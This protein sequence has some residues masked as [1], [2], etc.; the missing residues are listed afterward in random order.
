M[1]SPVILKNKYRITFICLLLLSILMLSGCGRNGYRTFTTKNSFCQFSFEYP[2]AYSDDNRNWLTRLISPPLNIKEKYFSITFAYP[3]KGYR[4]VNPDP[5]NKQSNPVT[6]YHEPASIHI[7]VSESDNYTAKTLVGK[8]LNAEARW[9]NYNLLERS[10]IQ[11]SGISAEYAHFVSS[12]LLPMRPGPG[13][14]IPLK[15][16]IWAYFD[17][18]GL[19][20][21]I[22]VE[23]EGEMAEQAR[24]DFEHVIQTFKIIKP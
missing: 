10:N 20:W 7:F 9:A 14:D 5:D 2:S 6:V 3:R 23:S 4:M 18:N 1:M 22:E 8:L 16:Y 19:I 11:V 21:Q 12:S 17:Y 24:F 15:H 13:E